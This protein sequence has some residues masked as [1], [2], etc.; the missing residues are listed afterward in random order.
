M[1][2]LESS[3]ERIDTSCVAHR[4][5]LGRASRRL[6]T[7]LEASVDALEMTPR[8]LETSYDALEMTHDALEMSDRAL[9]LSFKDS[10]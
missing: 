7:P 1:Q 9:E 3:A 8:A 4:I 5:V 10:R 2:L 6:L